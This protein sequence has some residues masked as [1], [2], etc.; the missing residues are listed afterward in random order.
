MHVFKL[1][2]FKE[3]PSYKDYKM[4]YTKN[5]CNRKIFWQKCTWVVLGTI[6]IL[7]YK[8]SIKNRENLPIGRFIVAANHTCY[9]DPF[10]CSYIT[11]KPLAYM[12]K[13][14]LFEKNYLS[15][16][17]LDELAAFA[18]NRESLEISTIKTVKEIFKTPNWSLGIFPEGGIRR[19]KEFSKIT[20][21]F[22]VIAQMVKCDILPIGITGL[23]S[24]NWNPF[25]KK[26]IQVSIGELISYKKSTDEILEEWIQQVAEMNNYTIVKEQVPDDSKVKAECV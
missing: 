1:F 14:E 6:F 25:K 5:F 23:E 7:F 16:L 26:K 13:K 22:A 8:L 19:N 9:F 21:G 10:I 12:A 24:Y 3:K 18:V 2:D 17:I 4:R 11:W 20:K 15:S